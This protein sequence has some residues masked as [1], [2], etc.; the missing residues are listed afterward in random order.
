MGT[1]L[2][3]IDMQNGVCTDGIYKLKQTVENINNRIKYFRDHK[4][5]IIFIQHIDQA[6]RP[7][8]YDWKIM[9]QINYFKDKDITIQKTHADAFYKTDLK[10]ELDRLR[11]D[12]L[13]ITG[14]QTEYCVDT[15]IRVAHNFGYEIVMYKGATTTFDNEFLSAEK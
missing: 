3:V 1:A 13:E 12:K 9:S 5:P 2:L 15:S 14:A 8:S 7:D 10:K 4:F 11:I 6:L